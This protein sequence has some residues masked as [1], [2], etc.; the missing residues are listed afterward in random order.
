MR[1]ITTEKKWTGA[2]APVR[3]AGRGAFSGQCSEMSDEQTTRKP[4]RPYRLNGLFL[5]R[6]AARA[7]SR[8]KSQDPPRTTR[9]CETTSLTAG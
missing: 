2:K 4:M 1:V 9:A 6:Q 8:M 3:A 5:L 7:S